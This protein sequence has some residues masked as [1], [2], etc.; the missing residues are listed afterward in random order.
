MWDLFGI[1]AGSSF[2]GDATNSALGVQQRQYEAAMRADCE[3]FLW[4]RFI[5][6]APRYDGHA[7]PIVRRA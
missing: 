5:E 4:Q 1:G 2:L 7:V 3:R 6:N